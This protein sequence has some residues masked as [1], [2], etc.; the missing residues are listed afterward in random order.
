MTREEDIFLMSI[1]GL[2]YIIDMQTERIKL[3]QDMRE[4]FKIQNIDMV[5]MEGNFLVFKNT[6]NNFYLIN[7]V[8]HFELIDFGKPSFDMK[9]GF[10]A[11]N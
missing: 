1:D 8:Y 9:P 4:Q 11:S 10:D 7:D 6:A 5:K 2:I 3:K